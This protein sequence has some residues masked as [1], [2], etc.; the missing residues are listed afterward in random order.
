MSRL[1][2]EAKKRQTFRERCSVEKQ[3]AVW[4][5]TQDPVLI[6]A[7]RQLQD[8]PELPN[9]ILGGIDFGFDLSVVD[10]AANFVYG[11]VNERVVK[12]FIDWEPVDVN[13]VAI[14]NALRKSRNAKLN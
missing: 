12:L 13:P 4:F 8:E 6:A 2:S 1:A 10:A 3:A 9:V 11:M 14:E 5:L 7:L